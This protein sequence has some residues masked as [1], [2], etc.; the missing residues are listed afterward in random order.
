MMEPWLNQPFDADA[1]PAGPDTD[2]RFLHHVL[3]WKRGVASLGQAPY[4]YHGGGDT[5]M[6]PVSTDAA[7][8][9]PAADALRARGF[10]VVTTPMPGGF[11]TTISGTGGGVSKV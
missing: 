11:H 8:A 3:D 1:L 5:L 9:E 2:W 4:V 6:W 10:T 7:Y